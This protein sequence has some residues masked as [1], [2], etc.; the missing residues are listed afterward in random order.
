MT[1]DPCHWASDGLQRCRRGI[2]TRRRT[3]WVTHANMKEYEY[4]YEGIQF[5][6]KAMYFINITQAYSTRA[7]HTCKLDE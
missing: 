5:K 1:F 6:I 3:P 4:K 7:I 2:E